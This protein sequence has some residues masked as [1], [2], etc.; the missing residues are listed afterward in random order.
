MP[1]CTTCQTCGGRRTRKRRGGSLVGDA[2]LAGTAVGLYSYF[3]KK[4]GR[5]LPTR[6]TRRRLV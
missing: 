4:G 5:K 3:K 1:E 2:V 6:K